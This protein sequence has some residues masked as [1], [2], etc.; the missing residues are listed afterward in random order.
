MRVDAQMLADL[1]AEQPPDRNSE[2]LAEDVPQGDLDAADRR[3]A[4]DAHPPEAVLG[5]HLLALLDVARVLPDEER[6]EIVNRTDDGPR[7]PLERRLAPADKAGLVRLDPDE[8]P[9][10]HLRVADA[11]GDRRDLQASS[12]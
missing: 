10:A 12:P 2:R 8:H 9:I 1:A 3:H 7:L 6:G 11:G 5:Q 4:D